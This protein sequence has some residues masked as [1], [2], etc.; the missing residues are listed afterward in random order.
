MKPNPADDESA[1]TTPTDEAILRVLETEGLL[2]TEDVAAELECSVAMAR[3]R[4]RAMSEVGL[5][6]RR[7]TV[8]GDVWLTWEDE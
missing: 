3:A 6:E 5:I 8:D 1:E 7:R 4:L 2:P